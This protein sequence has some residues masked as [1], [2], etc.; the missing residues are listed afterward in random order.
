MPGPV[1]DA[2]DTK[3]KFLPMRN[4]Y[5]CERDVPKICMNTLLNKTE[6]TKKCG[7]AK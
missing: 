7:R 5:S 4:L 3:E 6:S 2:W 1:P